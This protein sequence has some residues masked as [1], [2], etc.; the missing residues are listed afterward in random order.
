ME[1]ELLVLVVED[2]STDFEMLKRS[3]RQ[4]RTFELVWSRSVEEAINELKKRTFDLILLD[5][6]LPDSQGLESV[7]TFTELATTPV[8]VLSGLDD[9][10]LAL[11]SVQN[12]AH[13]YLV[14]GTFDSGLL[15]K[16]LR[17]AVERFRLLEELHESKVLV[18][19]ERELRRLE[20]SAHAAIENHGAAN[21][22]QSSLKESH[23]QVF[24]YAVEDYGALL[25]KALEQ[26][27]FKVEHNLSLQLRMLAE[28]L[29]TYKAT[30]RDIVEVHTLSV[31]AKIDNMPVKKI[32]LLNEEARYLLTGLLGHL[33]SFYKLYSRNLPAPVPAT[34][35]TARSS[36]ASLV[37]PD[38]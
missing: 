29:G 8:V 17:Y 27:G 28:A 33:C 38:G 5:L 26:R 37:K 7:Q 22:Q 15:T 24:V 21:E 31:G 12:G 30:P 14:K 34:Q 6:T 35:N 10:D 19:R 18:E 36:N 25:D 32:R 1:T 13:D 16:T 20:A 3:L 11:E 2:D 23:H 4:S 9:E